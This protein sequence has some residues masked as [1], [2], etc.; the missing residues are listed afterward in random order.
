MTTTSRFEET[1]RMATGVLEG[2]GGGGGGGG[3]KARNSK[4]QKHVAIPAL[5]PLPPCDSSLFISEI[6]KLVGFV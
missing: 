6:R 3:T 4:G 2:V 1:V 5:D